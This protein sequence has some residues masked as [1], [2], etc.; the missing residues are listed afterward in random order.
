MCP[1]LRCK[2]NQLVLCRG[3]RVSDNSRSAPWRPNVH[4]PPGAAVR[5]SGRL[6]GVN[7]WGQRYC[8]APLRLQRTRLCQHDRRFQLLPLP[9]DLNHFS[10]AR[11]KGMKPS[12]QPSKQQ[13]ENKCRRLLNKLLADHFAPIILFLTISREISSVTN[14]FLTCK[15]TRLIGFTHI[16]IYIAVIFI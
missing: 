10:R 12:V 14:I 9:R 13:S 3:V 11:R 4:L 16:F 8:A 2:F 7:C 5:V 1:T 6:Q 15:G